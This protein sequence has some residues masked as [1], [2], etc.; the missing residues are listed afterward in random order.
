VLRNQGVYIDREFTANNPNIIIAGP[1]T[2]RPIRER[3][4]TGNERISAV[5]NY[6]Q[7]NKKHRK[8]EQIKYAVPVKVKNS[9]K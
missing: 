6:K 1:T 5:T 7:T 9:E 4:K 2:I 3:E 8:K